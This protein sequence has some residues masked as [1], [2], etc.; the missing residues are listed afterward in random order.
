MWTAFQCIHTLHHPHS[1]YRKIDITLIKEAQDVSFIKIYHKDA[2]ESLHKTRELPTE[3]CHTSLC[4]WCSVYSN[5]VNPLHAEL[6]PI[7]HL[8]TLLGAHHIFH[9][10]RIRVKLHMDDCKLNLPSH[11]GK[12]GYFNLEAFFILH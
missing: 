4:A 2:N 3:I 11:F 9:V 1:P 8:L 6:N 10:S 7:C 12:P 5:S